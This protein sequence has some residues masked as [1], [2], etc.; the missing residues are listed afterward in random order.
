MLH[1]WATSMDD[2]TVEPRWG[3]IGKQKIEDAETLAPY[4]W[5]PW[6]TKSATSPSVHGQGQGGR[7]ALF[8]AVRPTRMHIVTHLSPKYQALRNSKNGWSVHEAGM[9]QLDDIVALVMQKP[10]DMGVDDNTIVVFTTDNGT[11]VFTWPDG[12][13]SPFAH[14]KGTVMEG[15]FRVRRSCAGR[16]TC[17]RAKWRTA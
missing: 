15:G 6:T 1:S 8:S 14:A 16:A 4:G 3:K 9:A 13:Q 10:T 2:P 7:Q 17:R 12:G 11:E 5:R